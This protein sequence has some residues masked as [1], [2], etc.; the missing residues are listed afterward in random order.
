MFK[1]PYFLL[2]IV[3]AAQFVLGC[4]TNPVTGEQELS[5]LSSNQ[6]INIGEKNYGSYRQAQGGDYYL[7]PSLQSYVSGVGANLHRSVMF[8]TY[9]MNLLF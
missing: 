3:I 2:I 4:S 9:P 5:L 6:E 1:T 8:P 7:D